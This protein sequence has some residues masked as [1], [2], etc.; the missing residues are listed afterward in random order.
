MNVRAAAVAGMFYPREPAILAGEIADHLEQANEDRL[1]PGFPKIVI[2]PHAGFIYSGAVAAH[3]YDLL[4]PARG[5]V[6]QVVLMG[7]CHRV[8]VRGLALPGADA[9]E[10][11][12]G[13]IPIDAEGEKLAR[14][15]PQ[16][17]VSSAT[18]A[19][20]HCIE[21]QLP[22]L[23]QVLGSFSLLPFVVGEASAEQVGEVIEKLWGGDETLFV[24]SSDM[25]HYHGYDTA[26]AMDQ[27]TAQSIM[28]LDLGINHEQACGA[29]PIRGALL[30]AQRRGLKPRLLDIRNS[31]DTAG[32]KDRVV[33]YA[34]FAIDGEP[35]TYT[36]AQGSLLLGA[37][38]Q[39]IGAALDRASLPAL[40]DERWL[41]EL[42][43]TFVTLKQNGSLRGCIGMLEAARPLGAD[44]IA[45]ARA[46][47]FS[48]PR[49]K[50]LTGP[51]LEKLDIEVSILS[52]PSRI[53]FEDHADLI[54]QL[55]PGKDGLIIE[56]TGGAKARRGTFLPQVW[57]S[58]PEPEN[59]IS[60][61]KLKAGMPADTRTTACRFK[62]YRVVKWIEAGTARA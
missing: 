47:A 58:I 43:A 40:P 35:R 10:T 22:Y 61:I 16:V 59:F 1:C 27:G 48:D 4:R 44:V 36:A 7:P 8:A 37:A 55:E 38:R 3:A 2:V 18:H 46:A 42:R 39:S 50:P 9:F 30:V 29:T 15:L 13:R 20:E 49:F 12:L 41:R 34:S 31:G 5:I 54:R 6:K 21:V 11:P 14:S 45:N 60:Q 33:G 23:Q 19:Q 53:A 25:S 51:E 24:I 26:R 17:C 57:E 28:D 32:G 52:R 62:R 56:S